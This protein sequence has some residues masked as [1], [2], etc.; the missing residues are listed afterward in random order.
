MQYY[1]RNHEKKLND[2]KNDKLINL[3]E[4]FDHKFIYICEK[5]Y[6]SQRQTLQEILPKIIENDRNLNEKFLR[7]VVTQSN[8]LDF[9]FHF[10][11]I[12]IDFKLEQCEYTVEYLID[13]YY[14]P[15][16]FVFLTR[17]IDISDTMKNIL[18]V[19]TNIDL[20]KYICDNNKDA[21]KY[22]PYEIIKHFNVPMINNDKKL[23]IFT[24]MSLIQM[25]YTLMMDILN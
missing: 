2:K 24:L 14:R 3:D 4:I 25:N 10:Y 9:N 5:K 19:L 13:L 7:S 11:N 1:I 20:I 16:K 15:E 6:G 18:R 8:D 21:C 12:D 22:L 17:K 23:L